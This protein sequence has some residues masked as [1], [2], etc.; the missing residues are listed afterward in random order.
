MPITKIV[1]V[2]I[3]I[4]TYITHG[5]KW[6]ADAGAKHADRKKPPSPWRLS[7]RQV[8]FQEPGIRGTP[9]KKPG[10]D[11]SKYTGQYLVPPTRGSLVSFDKRVTHKHVNSNTKKALQAEALK[12]T[13]HPRNGVFT[14]TYARIH[15]CTCTH[16]RAK[17]GTRADERAH[18]HCLS[19]AHS[20]TNTHMH[21]Q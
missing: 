12:A 5:Q 2:H 4:Y 10:T 16:T 8:S 18:T 6:G 7:L 15:T 11:S 3:Y 17:I 13:E 1:C 20:H 21:A 14:H 19:L 9:S